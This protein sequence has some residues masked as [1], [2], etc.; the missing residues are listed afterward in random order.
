MCHAMFAYAVEQDAEDRGPL[1]NRWPE[2]SR[3][4]DGIDDDDFV[5]APEGHLDGNNS[6]DR[7]EQ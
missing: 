3:R 5:E 2:K 7:R 1:P 6:V 4:S